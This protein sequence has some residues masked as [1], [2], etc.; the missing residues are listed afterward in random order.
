MNP[1]IK[2]MPAQKDIDKF[3]AIQ[4]RRLSREANKSNTKITKGISKSNSTG[5]KRNTN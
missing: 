1:K 2:T 5:N 4:S 3:F